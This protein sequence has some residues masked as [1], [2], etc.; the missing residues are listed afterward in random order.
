VAG[1]TK[2]TED[3]GCPVEV[4]VDIHDRHRGGFELE[5]AIAAS[6]AIPTVCEITQRWV[7]WVTWIQA[8]E[9]SKYRP[10]CEFLSKSADEQRE[11]G[12]ERLRSFGFQDEIN[13]KVSVSVRIN[14]RSRE[15]ESIK[16]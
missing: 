3:I 10:I 16:A 13:A 6:N 1:V 2:G 14:T 12:H 7:G 15:A 11:I 9:I 5:Y 4:P 8:A